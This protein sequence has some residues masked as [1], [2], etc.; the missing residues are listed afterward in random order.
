[1]VLPSGSLSNCRAYGAAWRRAT[2]Q[3]GLWIPV[4]TLMT[5]LSVYLV[6]QTLEAMAFRMLLTSGAAWLIWR[7]GIKDFQKRDQEQFGILR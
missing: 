1:M 4:Y 7:H 2:S 6:A 3:G 5:S